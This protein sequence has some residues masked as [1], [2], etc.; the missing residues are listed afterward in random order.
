V[1][2]A[3]ALTLAVTS[4]AL[5]IPVFAG[6]LAKLPTDKAGFQAKLG[7]YV[8]V[9]GRIDDAQRLLEGDRFRCEVKMDARE[10]Y[11]V[12]DRT[13]GAASSSAQVRYQVVMRT[14]GTTISS[15]QATVGRTGP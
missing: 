11:V 10:L 3:Y 6:D 1:I 14:D 7:T 13:D 8:R 12:C 15:M 9:G 5:A 4:S 2:R